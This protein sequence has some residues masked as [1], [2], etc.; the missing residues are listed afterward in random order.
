MRV[1]GYRAKKV[2]MIVTD[3][4]GRL[5]IFAEMME[6]IE[7]IHDAPEGICAECGH[8]DSD[9]CPCDGAPEADEDGFYCAAFAAEGAR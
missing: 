1:I 7:Y 2:R 3:D 6:R 9:A 8:R 4:P 5:E